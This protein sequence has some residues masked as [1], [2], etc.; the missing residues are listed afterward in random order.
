MAADWTVSDE[1]R[2]V[3]MFHT[4]D[5]GVWKGC[6]KRT[7]ARARSIFPARMVGLYGLVGFGCTMTGNP[8]LYQH[9]DRSSTWRCFKGT[10]N[11]HMRPIASAP[12]LTILTDPPPCFSGYFRS[13]WRFAPEAGHCIAGGHFLGLRLALS[14]TRDSLTRMRCWTKKGRARREQFRRVVNSLPANH[15]PDHPANA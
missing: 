2:N 8:C 4:A 1:V 9:R 12:G 7:G 13:I 11:I 15:P 6:T 10:T 5:A 14:L 3:A